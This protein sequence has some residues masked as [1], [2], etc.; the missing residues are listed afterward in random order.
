MKTGLLKK[1]RRRYKMY[2]ITSSTYKGKFLDCPFFLAY[3]N[4][5]EE[6]FVLCD[7]EYGDETILV[8]EASEKI[9]F[10]ILMNKIRIEYGANFEIKSR[11]K[12]IEF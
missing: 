11:M 6:F 9:I 8:C 10:E 1:I 3:M 2:K 4:N 7:N 12:K 5:F